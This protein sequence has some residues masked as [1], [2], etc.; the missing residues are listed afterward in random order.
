MAITISGSL[1]KILPPLQKTLKFQWQLLKGTIINLIP[2]LTVDGD[3]TR[4]LLECSLTASGEKEAWLQWIS[5][6][7][8]IQLPFCLPGC[9]ICLVCA[10]AATPSP[11]GHFCVFLLSSI[12]LKIGKK[13]EK[14]IIQLLVKNPYE[15]TT[16]SVLRK[17]QSQHI[18]TKITP[19][20]IFF[21][22]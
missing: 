12:L 8:N 3:V 10:F 1:I 14:T 15:E 11:L 4:E 6:K 16:W 18:S 21:F 22:T 9:G 5:G 20:T 13:L 17:V 7:W 2:S 19:S